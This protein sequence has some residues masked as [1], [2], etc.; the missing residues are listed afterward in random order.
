MLEDE[1]I[2]GNPAL[3]GS[4]KLIVLSGCSSGG[5]STLLTEMAKR[6]Y[7]VLPEAGRQIVKE[8]LF[9]TGDALPWQNLEKFVEL[10]VSRAIFQYNS[11]CSADN[12]VFFDRSIVDTI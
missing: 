8:Q 7:T 2:A 9:I 10:S 6:G 5:K 4:N 1:Y 11:V 3:N 12:P